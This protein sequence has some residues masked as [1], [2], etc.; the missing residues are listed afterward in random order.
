MSSV[1]YVHKVEFITII[2]LGLLETFMDKFSDITKDNTYIF[3]Y[4]TI[5]ISISKIYI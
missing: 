4:N 1:N 3:Q 5:Y 2:T